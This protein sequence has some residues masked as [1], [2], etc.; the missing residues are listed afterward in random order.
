M[1]IYDR[2]KLNDLR[3]IRNQFN[4]PEEINDSATTAPSKRLIEL[5]PAYDKVAFGILIS[6]RIGL[7]TIRHECPHFNQWLS[8]IESLGHQEEATE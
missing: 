6:K 2:S 8:R 1:S 3:N 5:Y 4:T 7:E